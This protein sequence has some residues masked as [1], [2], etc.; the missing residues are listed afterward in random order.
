MWA[1]Y[2]LV[3][4]NGWA[5][6]SSHGRVVG[7]VLVPLSARVIV[8][9][10]AVDTVVLW[11]WRPG[12]VECPGRSKGQLSRKGLVNRSPNRLCRRVLTLVQ[13]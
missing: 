1:K 6:L 12:Q 8:G 11:S 13:T 7:A 10:A 2:V 5:D 3:L 9:R 4:S